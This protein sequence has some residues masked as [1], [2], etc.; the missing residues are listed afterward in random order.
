MRRSVRTAPIISAMDH[1]GCARSWAATSRTARGSC[2]QR[3]T[4][5]GVQPNTELDF[6]LFWLQFTQGT[7]DGIG[8]TGDCTECLLHRAGGSLND[9]VG[10]SRAADTWLFLGQ[11]DVKES[12]TVKGY[13]HQIAHWTSS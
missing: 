5:L 11:L 3:G 2:P 7:Q 13:A 6:H 8:R 1:L 10:A 9:A 4:Q 12:A